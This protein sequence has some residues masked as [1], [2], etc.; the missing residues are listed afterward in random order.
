MEN[1]ISFKTRRE[2]RAWL[3]KNSPNAGEVWVVYYKKDSGKPS[4]T[5]RESLEEALCFGWIDGIRKSIDSERYTNRF[6]PRRA[7]SKWSVFNIKL[8]S[9]LIDEGKMTEAGL[10]AFNLR[11]EQDKQILDIRKAK[12]VRLPLELEKEIKLNEKAWRSFL[13]MA[14]SYQ[15]QYAMFL[16]SAKRPETREKRLKEAIS[17]LE[18]N[19]KLEQK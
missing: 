16:L 3:E 8:A 14:P 15:K 19:K 10:R 2:W 11:V 5:Y 1:E 18:M 7:G 13:D 12:E 6:T 9:R 17:L 4:I